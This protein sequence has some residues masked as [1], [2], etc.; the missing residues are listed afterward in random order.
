MMPSVVAVDESVLALIDHAERTL[1]GAEIDQ[2]ISDRLNREARQAEIERR[3]DWIGFLE[4]S[5]N[6]V[7]GLES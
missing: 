5:T 2:C 1:N 6:F 3:A 7:A 4:N